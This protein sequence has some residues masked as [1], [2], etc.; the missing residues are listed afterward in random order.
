M[1]PARC[2][3]IEPNDLENMDDYGRKEEARS[4]VSFVVGFLI[5]L[6][7]MQEVAHNVVLTKNGFGAY[8]IPRSKES[9]K[10]VENGWLEVCGIFRLSSKEAFENLESKDY[11]KV[12]RLKMS[13]DEVGFLEFIENIKKKFLTQFKPI[14]V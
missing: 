4:S 5:N 1:S 8:I 7:L 14:N 11:Q 2:L 9:I 12:V 10:G 13:I 3:Y 6:L